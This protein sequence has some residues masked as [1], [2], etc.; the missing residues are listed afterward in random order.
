MSWLAERVLIALPIGEIAADNFP[1]DGEYHFVLLG[2][3]VPLGEYA[4]EPALLAH[5]A[6]SRMKRRKGANPRA[7]DDPHLDRCPH[8]HLDS[9]DPKAVVT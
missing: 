4:Q 1:C 8:E 9:H 3:R 5:D 6:W 2:Q 7:Q